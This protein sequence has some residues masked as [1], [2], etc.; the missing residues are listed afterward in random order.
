MSEDK[1]VDRDISETF[2]TA[3]EIGLGETER[4]LFAKQ[5]LF[6]IALIVVVAGVSYAY[7]PENK[8]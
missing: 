3:S 5:L 2:S 8:A 1:I 7:N 4:L 6:V